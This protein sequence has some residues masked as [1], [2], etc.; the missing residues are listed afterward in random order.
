MPISTF[1]P[2][3]VITGDAV[4]VNP[5][6]GM[7]WLET[8]ASSNSLAEKWTWINDGWYSDAYQSQFYF[9]NVAG[10]ADTIFTFDSSK[11]IYFKEL[12]IYYYA[13]SATTATNY[14]QLEFKVFLD[15]VE[16]VNNPTS[17]PDINFYERIGATA[18]N[19]KQTVD[20]LYTS[21]N[22]F[23]FLFNRIGGGTIR[24]SLGATICYR[25]QRK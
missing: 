10:N 14:Y 5:F 19:I 2:K 1:A 11:N 18:Y 16:I 7:T 17:L 25:Y 21:G 6:N 23:R 13:N 3:T 22:N 4:P 9:A 15:K 20:K 12:I 24:A 8:V